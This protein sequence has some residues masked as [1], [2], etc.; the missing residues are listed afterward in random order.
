MSAAPTLTV[1]LGTPH[2][3]LESLG[4]QLARDAGGICLSQLRLTIADTIGER[5]QMAAVAQEPLDRHWQDA[6]STYLPEARTHIESYLDAHQHDPVVDVLNALRNAI[7]PK[8]LIIVDDHAGFRIHEVERWFAMAPDALLVHATTPLETFVAASTAHYRRHLFVPPDYRD[9][10]ATNAIP[11]LR[12]S[13][14]WYQVQTTLGLAFST[15]EPIRRCRRV[16]PASVQLTL[17]GLSSSAMTTASGPFDWPYLSEGSA[18]Q[19]SLMELQQL[20]G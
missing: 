19:P 9:H 18:R 10:N 12:P 1:I 20:F 14:A 15:H 2:S 4:Q 7:A 8:P 17:S 16:L 5:V 11:Q 3:G 6:L 13:L